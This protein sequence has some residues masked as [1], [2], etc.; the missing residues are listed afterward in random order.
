[1]S[2]FYHN[3]YRTMFQ[4]DSSDQAS[5]G[6][7]TYG[8]IKAVISMFQWDIT[9]AMNQQQHEETISVDCVRSVK[10]HHCVSHSTIFQAPFFPHCS[11]T[12][13]VYAQVRPTR[14]SSTT[15]QP[16]VPSSPLNHLLSS[17]SV[18]PAPPPQLLKRFLLS[19]NFLCCSVS[20]LVLSWLPT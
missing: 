15:S 5:P 3:C 19:F 13:S 4:Y 1:M 11:P 2:N 18:P 6:S 12:A 7:D 17:P 9:V 10:N 20:P 16:L 14:F 8:A